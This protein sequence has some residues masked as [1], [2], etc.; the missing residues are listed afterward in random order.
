MYSDIVL[1]TLYA[2]YGNPYLISFDVISVENV[3]RKH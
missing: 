2:L 1:V 3:L